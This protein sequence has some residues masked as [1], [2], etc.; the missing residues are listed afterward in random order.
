MGAWPTPENLADRIIAA[1][2]AE[3]ER[4]QDPQRKTRLQHAA[5]VGKGVLTGVLT[6]VITQQV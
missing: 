6:T 5:D 1:L 4:E 2:E 3:A